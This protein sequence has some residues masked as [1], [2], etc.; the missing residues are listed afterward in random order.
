MVTLAAPPTDERFPWLADHAP[1]GIFATD[2]NGHCIY[3]NRRWCDITGLTPDDA[4][5]RGWT[6]ALHPDDRDRVVPELYESVTSARSFLVERRAEAPA[7]Y[8]FQR[9][10]GTVTWVLGQAVAERNAAGAITGYVGTITD[11]TE[12]RRRE[13]IQ[14]ATYRIAEAATTTD[15]LDDFLRRLHGIVAELMPARNFYVAL[16]DAAAG[17]LSFPYFADETDP[18]CDTRTRPLKRGMTEYVLRTGAPLLATPAIYEDLTARGEVE[19]VGAPS[20]DWLGVPLQLREQTIGV[21]AAQTYTDAVRL[22]ERDAEILRFVSNQ[23]AMV[24]ERKRAEGE[25]RHSQLFLTRSQ[26]AA[27]I[28]SWE[29]DLATD[30]ATWS[31]ELYRL[32]GLA[33]QSVAIN[34][35]T[36]LAL[37]HPDDR[38]RVRATVEQALADR[39][40]YEIKYRIVRP[41]GRTRTL[42]GRGAVIVDD[43]DRPVRILGTCQDTTDLA[44]LEEKLVLSQKLEAVGQ[45]AGGVA[46]DFNNILTAIMSYGDLVLDDLP[47][48]DPRRGDLVEIK[49]AAERAA[50]LTRQLLAFSRRQILQPRVLELN[51]LVGN[52]DPMVRRLIGED[53]EVVTTLQPHLGRVEADPGQLEQVIVNLAVNARDAM[54][55]GGRLVITTENVELDEAYAH[56]H[57]RM[58]PGRYVMLAVSDTGTGMDEETKAHV[59]EPFFTTKP[60]G[61]GTGLGLATVYGIV[62]QSGGY[63]WVYSELGHGT[64]FKIYLPRAV[65][66][67]DAA[68]P[69]ATPELDLRGRETVLLVEDEA[70][71][72]KVARMGLEKQGYT[73]L[74]AANGVEAMR[75]AEACRGPIHLVVTDVIMPELG[76]RELIERLG[77]ARPDTRVLFMSGYTDDAIVRH[78]VLQAGI[79]FLEKPFTPRA[80]VGAVRRVLDNA[81]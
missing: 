51:A 3:V 54:P 22:S 59:F 13:Q 39:Q 63:V 79:P 6:R 45:L 78:G 20:L 21:V 61:Q 29:A 2:R 76:G 52:L 37:C 81:G 27:H 17:L 71:V 25:L 23:I 4:V 62:K 35:E 26:E 24:I 19:L 66:A 41:D 11:I 53:I 73:V 30:R 38:A 80:L 70:A 56:R 50:A 14:A 5:G 64:T 32:Y 58:E 49:R 69:T 77:A 18:H 44:Q 16:Y 36:F 8:R 72:R 7:E 65:T 60:V 10:D 48:A 46:H 28:G 12:Q 68:T 67:A 9:P 34:Y 43:A 15:S 55:G 42:H 75:Q 47:D 74:E 57:G 31:D 1:V 33:P 40:P